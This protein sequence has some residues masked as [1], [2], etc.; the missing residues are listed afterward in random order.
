MHYG[1]T[2][3]LNM[4]QALDSTHTNTEAGCEDAGGYDFTIPNL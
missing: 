3:P 2:A 4:C 1:I